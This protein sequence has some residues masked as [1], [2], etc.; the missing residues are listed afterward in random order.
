MGRIAGE[1]HRLPAVLGPGIE[2]L[3]GADRGEEEP[4]RKLRKRS[5][6]VQFAQT[7]NDGLAVLVVVRHQV[8]SPGV[9][10]AEVE[11]RRGA[12]RPDPIGGLAAAV[13]GGEGGLAR[14]VVLREN[15][16]ALH[17]FRKLESRRREG[18]RGHVDVLDEIL[19]H[20]P[21]GDAGAADDEG[22]VSAFVIEE[23]LAPRMADAVVGH[24]DDERVL[25]QT[26]PFQPRHHLADVPVGE[27]HAVEVGRPI[28][29]HHRIVRIVGGQGDFVRIDD[30]AEALPRLPLN[31]GVGGFALAS[32]LAAVELHLHE[33]GL[34]FGAPGPIVAVVNRSVPVEVVVRFAL[35]VPLDR[36]PAMVEAWNAAADAGVVSGSLQECRERLDAL[37]QLDAVL[38]S[39]AAVVMRP[40]RGLVA[41]RDHR[42][43]A[44]RADRRSHEGA[45]ELRPFPREPVDV[46]GLDQALTV[47]GKIRR[48]V[49]DDDPEQV[50]ARVR[51]DQDG[52]KRQAQ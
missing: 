43:A 16:A 20:L 19:A 35:A 38:S 36:K 10:V 45:G 14:R 32:Q 50:R 49:I 28:A 44:A 18:D 30:L 33:E 47:A 52:K 29:T 2:L 8:G 17:P 25:E 39:T 9:E 6:R 5:C 37:G 7:P 42:R 13:P 23:L 21:G 3:G 15:V 48:H 34:P 26:L 51:R 22:N 11:M 31:G 41:A 40:D 4:L 46:R 12:H 24:E 27:A 1:V